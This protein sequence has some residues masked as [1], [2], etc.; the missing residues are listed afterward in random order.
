M[1]KQIMNITRI[2]I[3]SICVLLGVVGLVLPLLVGIPCLALAV[4]C[5]SSL[6]K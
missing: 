4:A 2:A 5:F 3:G 1:L 6:E